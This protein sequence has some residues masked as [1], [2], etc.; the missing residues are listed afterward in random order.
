MGSGGDTS[1]SLAGLALLAVFGLSWRLVQRGQKLAA[2]AQTAPMTTIEGD[3]LPA[4]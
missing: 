1:V 2:T 3:A 4:S